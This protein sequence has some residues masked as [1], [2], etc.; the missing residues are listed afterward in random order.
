MLEVLCCI[1]IQKLIR[2]YL[3][4]V[5]TEASAAKYQGQSTIAIV[6]QDGLE[7]TVEKVTVGCFA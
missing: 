3:R 6:N 2:A 4:R 5:C 7:L 1:V